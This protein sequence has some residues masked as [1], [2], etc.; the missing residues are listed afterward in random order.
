M[1]AAK[2]RGIVTIYEITLPAIAGVLF[3]EERRHLGFL[4]NR[5]N[6]WDSKKWLKRLA[7]E[8]RVADYIVAQSR[9]TVQYL[10][11]LDIQPRKIILLPLGRYR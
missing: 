1:K 4:E 3:K 5:R 10:M 6:I 11:Q 2:Q 9:V 7:E 8:C